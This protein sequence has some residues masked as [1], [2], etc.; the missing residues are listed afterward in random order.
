MTSKPSGGPF[1]GVWILQRVND[2]ICR[3]LPELASVN[4]AETK[5]SGAGAGGEGDDGALS[6]V[7]DE[8]AADRAR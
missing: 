2:T 3:N 1:S 4:A 5:G 6:A 8:L 7:S